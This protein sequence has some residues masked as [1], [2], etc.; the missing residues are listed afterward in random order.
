MLQVCKKPETSYNFLELWHQ[1]LGHI[2]FQDLLSLSNKGV[3]GLPRLSGKI[4]TV[5]EGCKLGK[6]T[7]SWHKAIYV[8]TT[9][10]P[11]DLMHMD[12]VRPIQTESIGGK[13]YMLVLA[14]D[15]SR[16][17]W[18]NFLREKS[19]AFNSFKGLCNQILNEKFSTNSCIVRLR[20]DHDTEFKNT[21][22]VE[23]CD[24]HG[25]MPEHS[26]P[27]TP[28]H[29]DIV[30]RKNRVL[31]EM[32]RVLLCTDGLTHT[33]WAEATN[34]ACYTINRVYLRPGTEQT[35]YELWKGKKPNVSHLRTFDNP[36]FILRDWEHLAN[37]M[38]EVIMV[39][40][41]ATH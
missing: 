4:D 35:S 29:N 26:T 38:L 3:R 18:V 30:E 22:F 25:I 28:Q 17:I 32:G 31:M 1:R 13:R 23:F 27:I 8:V 19:D 41:L 36:F 33:F 2:N 24:E 6:Q 21:S 12:L 9:S 15:F 14:D 10:Q 16:F 7:R 40:F 37:L 39:S 20:T 5:C 34:T 11:L